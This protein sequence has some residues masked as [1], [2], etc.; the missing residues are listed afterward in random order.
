MKECEQNVCVSLSVCVREPLSACVFERES[1][2]VCVLKVLEMK[3]IK[4]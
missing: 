3:V 4:K 2:C 1:V